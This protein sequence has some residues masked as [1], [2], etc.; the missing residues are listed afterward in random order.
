MALSDTVADFLLSNDVSVT[1]ALGKLDFV[2][3]NFHVD[4]EG[5]REIGHK[6][7]QGAICVEE[8]QRSEGSQIAAVYTAARDRLSVPA[9]LDLS[10]RGRGS[11]GQ[12]AMIV[13][14]CTHALMDFHYYQT[15]GAIQEACAYVAE[16]IY[17]TSKLIGLSGGGNAQSQAIL[18]AAAAIVTGRSMH[19][20][21]GQ[22]LL[23]GDADVARLISA[24]S[25][26]DSYRADA[27]NPYRSDGICGGLMNPWYM[28][29]H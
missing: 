10:G 3:D 28:P 8:A 4:Y 26:H 1:F 21:A 29:R 6:I 19:R 17:A 12:Q 7:R 18:D 5:Y 23:T 16:A 20:N 24:V 2:F 25:A 22:R 13:H 11:I 9:G 15:T 14:E 27:A